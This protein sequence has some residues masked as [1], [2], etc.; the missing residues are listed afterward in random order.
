VILEARRRK[1]EGLG[2]ENVIISLMKNPEPKPK[3]SRSVRELIENYRKRRDTR[4]AIQAGKDTPETLAGIKREKTIL[5]L[6]ARFKMPG[7]PL[8]TRLLS[9]RGKFVNPR[10][11]EAVV[12]FRCQSFISC[13]GLWRTEAHMEEDEM[14]TIGQSEAPRTL[15]QSG[16]KTD[17]HPGLT[18]VRF[19]ASEPL[20]WE[21]QLSEPD[22][23]EAPSAE[24]GLKGVRAPPPVQRKCRRVPGVPTV[25]TARME[26]LEHMES[27]KVITDRVASAA[28]LN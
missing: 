28:R 17:L 16:I 18:V 6:R 13:R 2:S 10:Q 21:W 15:K 19:V 5:E 24:G 12:P 7:A 8:I 26:Y 22:S 11:A 9:S 23:N 20:H 3:R 14:G 25:L 27:H 1:S 4:V